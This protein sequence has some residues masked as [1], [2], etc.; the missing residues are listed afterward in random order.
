[1]HIII[2]IIIGVG[3]SICESTVTCPCACY[4]LAH[5]GLPG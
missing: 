4:L 1:M 2:I 3:E 5:R